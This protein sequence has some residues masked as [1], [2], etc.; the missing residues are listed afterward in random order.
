MIRTYIT[1]T[2]S[3]YNLA[4]ELPEEYLG[5]ELELIIFKRKE[6]F[7]I[8]NETPQFKI[9]DKYKGVFTKDDAINF[10]IH[11]QEMRKEWGNT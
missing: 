11:T 3:K 9:S 4:L 8:E 2:Q 7:F 1:P 5:Q 10:N 6:E